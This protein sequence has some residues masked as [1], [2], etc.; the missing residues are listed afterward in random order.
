MN[1]LWAQSFKDMVFAIIIVAGRGKHAWGLRRMPPCF[2]S[3]FPTAHLPHH[4]QG[5]LA[6]SLEPNFRIISEYQIIKCVLLVSKLFQN[7][8][9]PN[10]TF[11]SLRLLKSEAVIST[12][13]NC[14]ILFASLIMRFADLAKTERRSNRTHSLQ[15]FNFQT[16]FF[17]VLFPLFQLCRKFT[18]PVGNATHV[19]VC[20][21]AH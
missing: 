16:S 15:C 8:A 7:S 14:S 5:L 17:K 18:C 12:S 6:W 3:I 19:S 21:W 2:S 1:N 10:C 11:Q 4:D 20:H 13:I 9:G